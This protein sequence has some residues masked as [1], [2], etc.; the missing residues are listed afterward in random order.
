MTPRTVRKPRTGTRHGPQDQDGQPLLR[1][2]LS[3]GPP[4]HLPPQTLGHLMR[5]IIATAT[6]AIT[7]I[8]A[9]G[10]AGQA[11]PRDPAPPPASMPQVCTKDG[12]VVFV[13]AGRQNS[14]APV[15][16]GSMQAAAATA[17]HEGSAIG[18]VDLDGRPRLILAG[19]FSDPGANPPALQAAQQ[20]Y[21]STLTSAVQRIRAAYPHAD[22]LDAL[23]VA[24]HAI[25]AACPHG[26]TIYLEDSGLQET[27]LVNFRQAGM[28]GATP[29]GVVSFLT[30]N[31]NLPY[32]TGMT[33]VLA[34]IGDTAPPQLPLS[35]SQQDNVAAIWSAIAGAGGA[36]SVRIDPAPLS[37][38]APAHVPAVLLVPIPQIPLPEIPG[39]QVA[40]YNGGA[41]YTLSDSLRDFAV[42]SAALTPVAEAAL[43]RIAADIQA[44]ASG[45]IITCTGST[46][47]TGT[48]AFDLALSEKRAIT[49]CN[50]LARQGINPNLLR[51]VGTG[52]ATPVAANPSL[53]R[54]II[55]T[56]RTAHTPG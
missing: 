27:G 36:T 21:L 51:T 1:P 16:T 31:H 9:A 35:I 49:V 47:G 56:A 39:A 14:P 6:I 41:S 20:N 55:T 24:G 40:P 53:R 29:A 32:L 52:K 11:P 3:S 38:P 33:V 37:G 7:A 48:A 17:V 44:R 25:R 45:Q 46:D 42:G 34:G 30:H 18:L 4:H 12:P 43:A 10:C 50:Y 22:V 19:A 26:G 15:L 23:N 54:V 5:R 28:L 13:I 2:G 8:L